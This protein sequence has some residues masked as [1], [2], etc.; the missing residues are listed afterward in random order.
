[1]WVKEKKKGNPLTSRM[2]GLS[3]I[4]KEDSPLR[5][6]INTI[7]GPTCLLAKLLAQTLKPLVSLTSDFVKCSYS[8]INEI[9]G[10]KLDPSDILVI[11]LHQDLINEV[12]DIISCIRNFN[13]TFFFAK[14]VW[15]CLNSKL[16]SFQGEFYEQTCGVSMDSPLSLVVA[17]IFMED[18]KNKALDSTPFSSKIW[19]CFVD[20]TCVIWPHGHDKLELF[21]QHLKIKS[22][23]IKLT[24]EVKNNGSLMFLDVLISK[25]DDG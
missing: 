13:T 1:M 9:T 5:P 25:N 19:K 17:N 21:L 3:K 2:S 8:F 4:H 20:D 24:M 14:L 15:L 11:S 6:I 16:F 10:I 18:F 12:V 7:S 23:F 22:N